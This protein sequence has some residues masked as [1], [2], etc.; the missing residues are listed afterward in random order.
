[1]L[2]QITKSCFNQSGY[3]T[4]K[5]SLN[6]M[7]ENGAKMTIKMPPKWQLKCPNNIFKL[8][9]SGTCQKMVI[10]STSWQI[11]KFGYI[12][13]MFLLFEPT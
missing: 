13:S 3:V 10:K 7:T 9:I 2:F 11:L 5:S 12:Y 6:I 8:S 4:L 1:M